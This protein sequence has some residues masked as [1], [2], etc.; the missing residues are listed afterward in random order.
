MP[1]YTSASN[2][3][4]Y[5]WLAAVPGALVDLFVNFT[6]G[7][8]F[9]LQAPNINRGF[10]SARMDDLILHDYGWRCRLAIRI[11]GTLLEPYDMS[12]PKQHTTHGKFK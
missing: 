5:W 4:W 8:V 9:F 12:V 11:V 7:T 10:L 1:T 6:W 2:G 3:P